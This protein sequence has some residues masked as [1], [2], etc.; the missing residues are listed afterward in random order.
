VSHRS[1][2]VIEPIITDPGKPLSVR[3]RLHHTPDLPEAQ[4]GEG[5]RIKRRYL[6]LDSGNSRGAAIGPENKIDDLLDVE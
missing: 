1:L 4:H 3:R 6:I 5:L 2:P